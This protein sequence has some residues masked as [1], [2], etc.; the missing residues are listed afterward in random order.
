[1]F[2]ILSTHLYDSILHLLNPSFLSHIQTEHPDEEATAYCG[3]ADRTAQTI[4]LMFLPLFAYL[5][6]LI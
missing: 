2:L 3:S 5:V 4:A 1:M 6:R